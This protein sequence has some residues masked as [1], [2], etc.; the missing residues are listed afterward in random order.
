MACF[1][2]TIFLQHDA[3]LEDV[4]KALLKDDMTADWPILYREYYDQLYPPIPC[5]KQEL[6][7]RRYEPDAGAVYDLSTSPMVC[8][9][10]ATELWW[11]AE[12]IKYRFSRWKFDLEEHFG[13]VVSN[14][15]YQS[16]PLC[17]RECLYE[18]QR[19][20]SSA[21]DE[22]T[23]A[24]GLQDS[25]KHLR[26]CEFAAHDVMLCVKNALKMLTQ[27]QARYQDIKFWS[28]KAS[29]SEQRDI[30]PKR[31]GVLMLEVNEWLRVI[32]GACVGFQKD[33]K[34]VCQRHARHPKV[35]LPDDLAS[36]WNARSK[37][38]A[39]YQAN[40]FPP[41]AMMPLSDEEMWA[42]TMRQRL[43]ET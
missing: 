35:D 5:C 26:K 30:S 17:F 16:Y 40:R 28:T 14:E 36:I 19:A 4:L 20:K 29:E 1:Y 24:E 2:N 18:H 33:W 37:K 7:E 8:Q 23:Q 38:N 27:L 31:L 13:A 9:R 22:S 25:E 6:R 41:D 34:A 32:V 39:D 21:S 11:I 15:P 12:S 42:I 3:P 43:N 10:L